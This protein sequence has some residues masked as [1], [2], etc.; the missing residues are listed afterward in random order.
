MFMRNTTV[1]SQPCLRATCGYGGRSDLISL[2]VFR[3]A[4]RSAMES[5]GGVGLGLSCGTMEAL[6]IVVALRPLNGTAEMVSRAA[7]LMRRSAGGAINRT[8]CHNPLR[9]AM[10]SRATSRLAC[11]TRGVLV[12]VETMR[13]LNR[14][15]NRSRGIGFGYTEFP[16]FFIGQSVGN[17]EGLQKFD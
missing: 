6:E 5:R 8:V 13:P 9:S 12:I 1:P 4:L 2:T 3:S 14:P 16:L 15:L 10:E 7:R 11:E 17:F